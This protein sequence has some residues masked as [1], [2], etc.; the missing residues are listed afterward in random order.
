MRKDTFM[1]CPVSGTN[2]GTVIFDSLEPL[3]IYDRII[4]TDVV[5]FSYGSHVGDRFYVLP[6]ASTDEFIPALVEAVGKEGVTVLIPG[7]DWELRRISDYREVF[8]RMGVHLLINSESILR[9]CFD[10]AVTARMLASHG[11]KAPATIDIPSPDV[12]E[13]DEAISAILEKMDFPFLVKPNHHSGG[14]NHIEVIQDEMDFSQFHG[15]FAQQRIDFV[16]QEYIDAPEEEYTIG[17]MSD[18]EGKIISSFAL[19][20]DLSAPRCRK[21][22]VKSKYAKGASSRDI[23]VSG[24][25]TQGYVDDFSEARKWGEAVACAF[26]STGPLNIQCRRYGGDFYAFEINPRFSATTAIR[27][28][29]GH[30]DVLLIYNAFVKGINMGQQIYLRGSATR[31]QRVVFRSDGYIGR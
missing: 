28:A 9:N 1:I 31:G 4:T 7:S 19:L 24:G 11:F 13:R 25:L 5:G 20:R 12:A 30:N 8:A 29:M 27:S 18:L 17:V 14:S 6:W 26:E 10:K 16:A 22:S 23:V 21:L 3:S 2:T 15:R